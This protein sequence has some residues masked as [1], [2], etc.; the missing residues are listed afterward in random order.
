MSVIKEMTHNWKTT[1]VGVIL[2]VSMVMWWLDK[3]ETNEFI[4]VMGVVS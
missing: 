3:I 2:I 1:V 4:A